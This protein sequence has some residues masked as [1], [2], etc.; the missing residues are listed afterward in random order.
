MLAPDQIE[1][2][3]VITAHPDDVDFGAAGTIAVLTD[4]GVQVTYCLVTDGDAGGSDRTMSRA[5]MAMLRRREQ[6]AAAAVVGVERLIF[7]GRPDSRVTADLSLREALSRVIRE[8][9]PTVVL[10]QSPEFHFDRI[11]A[12]HPDH[13]ATGE[14]ALAAVY[15]DARNPFAFPA[16]L[17]DGLEPWT[18]P[19]VWL[20]G[21]PTN[22]S[23]VDITT[24]LDRKLAALRHHESQLADPAAMEQLVRAWTAGTAV[25]AGLPEGSAAEAFRLVPT[26]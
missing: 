5:E 17:T 7:L 19:E 23:Y 10:T 24:T 9:C 12:S 25:A 2:L 4:A 3:L 22:T 20:M 6:T 15:P 14:A 16:L 26:A 21:G 13:R 11:Y 1:R 18:V 8:V